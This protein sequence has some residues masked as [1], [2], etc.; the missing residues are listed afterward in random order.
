MAQC[1][2]PVFD[3]LFPDSEIQLSVDDLL[4]TLVEWHSL[5]KLALHTESTLND[6]DLLTSSLG[7]HLRKFAGITDQHV[8]TRETPS[9]QRKRVRRHEG[10]LSNN[11]PNVRIPKTFKMNTSKIHSIGDYVVHL[12]RYGPAGVISTQAVSFSVAI[13]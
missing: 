9:E 11:G 12:A 5:A 6:L 7:F 1:S 2:L 3:G 4:Y 8:D 13:L 10:S